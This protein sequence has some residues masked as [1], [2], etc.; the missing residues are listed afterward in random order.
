MGL[1][2]KIKTASYAFFSTSFLF[3]PDFF[4]GN[5]SFKLISNVYV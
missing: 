5:I 4:T 3:F 2:T 1:L